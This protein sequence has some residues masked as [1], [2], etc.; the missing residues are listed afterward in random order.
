MEPVFAFEP[1]N[2]SDSRDRTPRLKG[3]L[4]KGEDLSWLSPC[5]EMI[6]FLFVILFCLFFHM[7]R[8]MNKWP[9]IAFRVIPSLSH[10]TLEFRHYTTPVCVAC[11]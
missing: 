3:A 8:S 4:G 11:T 1:D 10:L 6:P 7:S 2:A 9:Y 5:L